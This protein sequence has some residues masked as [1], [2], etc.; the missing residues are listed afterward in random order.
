M[1]L[2]GTRVIICVFFFAL[3]LTGSAYGEI[4]F[5][6]QPADII[7]DE[8]SN[9]LIIETAKTIRESWTLPYVTAH[10][11]ILLDAQ[12]GDIL[13]ERDAHKKRPPASTTKILTAILAIE[14]ADLDEIA[15]VSEKADR[16]GE[17]TIYL[18][19]GNKLKL[20]ELIEGAL[21]R[22]GNDACV[23]IAEQIA[24]SHDEFVRLMNLRAISLGAKNSNFV[25]T[26]GLPAKDHYSSAYDL[27][28]I[29]RYAMN[30]PVFSKIVAQKT[31]TISFEVPPKSQIA[32]NT[33]KL[34]WSYP[35]ADGVK[36]G[37]TNAA[38]KC[39][40]ASASKE[41]RRLI[42][43]V[44]NAPDRFGDARRLLEWGFNQ[45]EIMFYGK[46][47]VYLA[48]YPGYGIP[49]ILKDELHL[50]VEKAV[51]EKIKV[52]INFKEG[53]YPP[54]KAGDVLGNYNIVLGEKILKTV[55]LLAGENYVG[56]A[57]NYS[58]TLNLVL[59]HVLDLLNKKG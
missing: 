55:P 21:I 17:S 42:C 16:V 23:A 26:N 28:L 14:L 33:N 5:N 2:S 10:S 8:E 22:S 6:Y 19:K 53:V 29:T 40:V 30:N 12:T 13:Y 50:C 9:D 1:K 57:L 48:N 46:K 56:R 51:K 7:P 20:R 35:F 31:A 49:L 37:T 27:A 32:N 45:T 44:L 52:Q 41:G 39:L 24:G 18:S 34:L 43:V 25:N 15:T 38:G 4:A 36:T 54:I 59:D 11:A 3:V 47:G 58:G